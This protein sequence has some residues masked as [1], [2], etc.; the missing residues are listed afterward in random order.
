MGFSK[1]A[2][3][4]LLALRAASVFAADPPAAEPSEPVSPR[5]AIP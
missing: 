3:I 4:A 5:A 2:T 1:L